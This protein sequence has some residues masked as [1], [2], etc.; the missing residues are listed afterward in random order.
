MNT[1]YALTP[2][3]AKRART[4]R[5]ER[6]R[7]FKFNGEPMDPA[8]I[9]ERLGMTYRAVCYRITKARAKGIRDLLPEHFA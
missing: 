8:Q 2:E 1:K 5:S 3:A 9:A 6:R 4:R 7:I